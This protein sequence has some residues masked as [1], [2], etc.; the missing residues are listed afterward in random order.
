MVNNLILLLLATENLEALKTS[1]TT[2][3]YV[4]AFQNKKTMYF[5]HLAPE[6]SFKF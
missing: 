1:V 2:R 6:F 4:D 3:K 5:N